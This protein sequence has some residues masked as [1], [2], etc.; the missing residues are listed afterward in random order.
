MNDNFGYIDIVLL[1]YFSTS[2]TKNIIWWRKRDDKINMGKY[3]CE[4]YEELKIDAE[5]MIECVY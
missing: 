2:F 1:E 4:S 3:V 5:I